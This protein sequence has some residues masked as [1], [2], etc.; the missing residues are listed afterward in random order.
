LEGIANSHAAL[1]FTMGMSAYMGLLHAWLWRRTD[2]AHLWVAMWCFVA[3]LY[4]GS[5]CVQF[6]TQ[7]PEVALLSAR[8]TFAMAPLLVATL[9]CFARALEERPLRRLAPG[10]F[11]VALLYAGLAFTSSWVV[12]GEVGPR[13]DWFGHD[14]LGTPVGPGGLLLLPAIAGAIAYVV[15]ALGRT[16]FLKRSERGALLSSLGLYAAM[17][18]AS[19]FSAMRWISMPTSA[20]FGPIV[21]ALGLNYLLVHRHRR[22]QDSL[23]EMVDERTARLGESEQRYRELVE[24]APVGVLACNAEGAL[25]TVNARLLEIVGMPPARGA[26]PVNVLDYEPVVRSGAA[27]T[28]RR[29]M[30]GNRVLAAEHRFP[31]PSGRPV[32]LRL[33]AAP[34]RDAEGRVT[35][36]L[37]IVEDVGE[38]RTLERRLRQSQRLE[39]V[40]QL[41]AGLAHEI[42]NPIAYV[43]ANLTLLREEWEHL[44][45]VAAKE[46]APKPAGEGETLIDESLEGIARVA[47]IVRDMRDFSRA[48]D[49]DRGPCDLNAV[50]ESAVRMASTWRRGATRVE[51]HYADLPRVPGA[52]GQLRQ[53]V[54]NL[55]VNALQAVD[56]GGRVAVATECDDGHAV[57]RVEDDGCGIEEEHLERLFDPFFTTKPAGEGTGLGLYV[58]YEIVRSHGGEIRVTAGPGRGTAFEVRLPLRAPSPDAAAAPGR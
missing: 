57:V 25:R 35:G 2:R 41:A 18:V 31:T 4:Q 30:D 24:H 53:V 11:G 48:A 14:Y 55:I 39:S 50:V 32:D 43:R 23:A 36:A 52:E 19:L 3:L 45:Q 6:H 12:K 26:A 40:G 37:G 51:E 44:R 17:G 46:D 56:E 7:D 9:V 8:T 27:E 58:S 47:G 5:R 49:E 29:C 22:L 1:L 34:L 15:R 28:L 20:E 33:T 16:P 13:T 54:L 42:N 38:R 10:V 21:V